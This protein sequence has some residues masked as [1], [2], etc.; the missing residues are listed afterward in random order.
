[1]FGHCVVTECVGE[2]ASRSGRVGQGLQ[3][4]ER[5]GGDDEQRS[6]RIE[7][8]EFGDQVGRIDIGDEPRGDAGVGIVPQGLIG[9]RRSE[10]GSADADVDDGLDAL[11]GG[12]GP[13]PVAHPVG[14]IAHR[15]QDGVDV[16]DH[17]LCV[18]GEPG[19]PGQS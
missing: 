5:L 10:V 13:P 8:V 4:G 19:V 11:A 3:G 9:H 14:E 12:A 6:G 16:V 1:M 15:V 18:D 2:P 7:S 17:V